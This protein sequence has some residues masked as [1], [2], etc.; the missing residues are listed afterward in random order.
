[1]KVSFLRNVYS[2]ASFALAVLCLI[3]LVKADTGSTT[4]GVCAGTCPG[5]HA[6]RS[7]G[8]AWSCA[9]QGTCIETPDTVHNC[10]DCIINVASSDP[11]I[12]R[13]LV[14]EW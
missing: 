6:V 10:T 11:V 14:E 9:N 2:P 1:M 4:F 13:C 5:A 8:G 12:C 3:S 7:V